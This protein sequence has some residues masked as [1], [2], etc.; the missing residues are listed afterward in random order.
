M[1][2]QPEVDVV[3]LNDVLT[4]SGDDA[5]IEISIT[6]VKGEVPLNQVTVLG[7]FVSTCFV[8]VAAIVFTDFKD[9]L[10][11]NWSCNLC[12]G[13]SFGSRI[14]LCEH[15][16]VAHNKNDETTCLICYL[17]FPSK[18]EM[19]RHLSVHTDSQNGGSA[20]SK[21]DGLKNCTVC[22][23]CFSDEAK[24]RAR[25]REIQNINCGAVCL[26]CAS[27]VKV[28]K[29]AAMHVLQNKGELTYK[30]HICD[31]SFIEL[32]T[33]SYHMRILHPASE[34]RVCPHCT[35]VLGTNKQYEKHTQLHSQASAN[36]FA[37]TICKWVYFARS[38]LETH[39]LSVHNVT[40]VANNL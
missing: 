29:M 6:D 5:D 20:N 35:R 11:D 38:A 26:L 21:A 28:S 30:C 8:F 37:C 7:L 31:K 9:P 3:D 27:E 18:F 25:L 34:K 39:L 2:E 4:Q 12:G 33:F 22:L 13:V 14:E 24:L 40:K 23:N 19:E 1:R 32:P 15:L 36:K 10:G 17:E 16:A